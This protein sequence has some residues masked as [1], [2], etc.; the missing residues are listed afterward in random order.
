MKRNEFYLVGDF[1]NWGDG[2][3]PLKFEEV[4]DG[5]FEAK[6][7]LP[8]GNEFKVIT[9]GDDDQAIW[10]GGTDETGVGY[11]LITN[12]LL[13][14]PTTLWVGAG[15]NFRM[16]EAAVYIVRITEA[17]TTGLKQGSKQRVVQ[18]QRSEAQ[19]QARRSWYLH[20]RWQEGY[21]EVTP[22]AINLCD[23]HLNNKAPWYHKNGSLGAILSCFQHKLSF[24][25]MSLEKSAK[26]RC[27]IM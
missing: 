2:V 16:Q 8:A 3:E 21:R 12:E 10:M 17:Q 13:N 27:V 7:D 24:K 1:N 19:R 4:E 11:Y 26:W 20:Q 14:V 25:K 23:Q 15:S 5:V 18:P 6:V 9:Y 22:V